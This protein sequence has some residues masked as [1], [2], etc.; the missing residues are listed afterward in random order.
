MSVMQVFEFVERTV[1]EDLEKSPDGMK[2]E[3]VKKVMWQLIQAIKFCHTHNVIHRDIKPENL[4]ISKNDVL[5][6]CDFGF[7]RTLGN[8]G[9]RYTGVLCFK[10]HFGTSTLTL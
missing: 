8:P 9:A 6:L 1:L 5:K 2:E 4:L 3:E 10:N 7:A